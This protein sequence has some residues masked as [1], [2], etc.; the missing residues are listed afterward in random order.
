M[1]LCVWLLSIS[2]TSQSFGL[3]PYENMYLYAFL[4]LNSLPC[5]GIL[6]LCIHHL[7][8]FPLADIKY[9]YD[10]LIVFIQVFVQ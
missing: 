3:L 6:C 7:D 8:G 9:Y 1:L 5:I 10:H 4:L 2:V